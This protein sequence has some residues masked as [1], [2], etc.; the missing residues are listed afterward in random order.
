MNIAETRLVPRE[1]TALDR[2]GVE[3][4]LLRAESAASLV[5]GATEV[6]KQLAGVIE[7]CR[8]YNH[9]GGRRFV[10][11]EGW[12]TLAAM[13][14][15]TARE[16]AVV[17]TPEGS[18]E[19]T[20][21]LVR[22]KDGQVISRASALCGADEPTWVGRPKYARRSM[23]STRATGK[24]C[25]L[26]F[27]WVMSLAGFEATPAEEMDP[28]EVESRPV[29]TD[30]P[31]GNGNVVRITSGGRISDK[32]RKRMY[33]IAKRAGWSD[34]DFRTF[35]RQRGYGSSAE[36][37]AEDYE[38]LCAALEQNPDPGSQTRE[39]HEAW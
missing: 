39:A 17:E 30:G 26:A 16:V 19:A 31:T 35:I 24:A 32:Q 37:R 7:Q 10:R 33:A 18:F 2:S 20:V 27:S 28:V 1:E 4:G 38:S 22:H 36:V 13:M 23:A 8:L 25:R 29:P 9:I 12:T 14:G 3:L 21:E 11:V 15:V 6:A 34:E 5:Q